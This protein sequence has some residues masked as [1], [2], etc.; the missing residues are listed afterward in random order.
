MSLIVFSGA[1][2]G[3]MLVAFTPR[4]DGINLTTHSYTECITLLYSQP[5]FLFDK[6]ISLAA[7]SSMMLP[8]RLNS[9]ESIWIYQDIE[10]LG[11]RTGNDGMFRGPSGY[12]A[13]HDYKFTSRNEILPIFPPAIGLDNI[14]KDDVWFQVLRLLRRMPSLQE[15]KVQVIISSTV[16]EQHQVNTSKKIPSRAMDFLASTN[17][18]LWDPATLEKW[19]DYDFSTESYAVGWYWHFV[20]TLKKKST[21]T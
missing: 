5:T 16:E 7:F 10:T 15:L 20:T 8:E 14:K 18:E 19:N 1:R 11:L 3:A 12:G 17:M 2:C 21:G 9:V 13:L 4:V 6:Y